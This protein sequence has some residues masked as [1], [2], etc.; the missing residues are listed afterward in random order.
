MP[1]HSNVSDR[2]KTLFQKEKKKQLLELGLKKGEFLQISAEKPV[3]E[4]A[5]T[6]CGH[7]RQVYMGHYREKSFHVTHFSLL[8]PSFFFFFFSLRQG[9]ALSPRLECSGGSLQ[10][11]PPGLKRF[12]CLRL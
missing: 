10:S 1:L 12:S 9:L 2:A 7:G 5:D 11:P 8:R 3:K 6:F 4:G